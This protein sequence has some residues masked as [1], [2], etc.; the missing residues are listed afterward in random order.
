MKKVERWIVYPVLIVV[1]ILSFISLSQ[2]HPRVLGL[3]YIGV[4]VGV[5]SLLVT[6]LISW[7]ILTLIDIRK[8]RDNFD[9]RDKELSVKIEKIYVDF[10]NSIAGI[11]N[12]QDDSYY[13]L[14]YMLLKC[15]HQSNARL[16]DNCNHT[17]FAILQI[18]GI[19]EVDKF[20]YKI[21]QETKC[22]IKYTDKIKKYKDLDDYLDKA[23]KVSVDGKTVKSTQSSKLNE[24]TITI[25]ENNF[26]KLK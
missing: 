15:V 4:V 8:I 12:K 2:G 13:Y 1:G 21:I 6:A 22:K 14:L 24:I 3:D 9:A 25:D 16:F 5:L 19:I 10:Y 20:K 17:I 7:Q 23:L 26:V 18:D 11:Y